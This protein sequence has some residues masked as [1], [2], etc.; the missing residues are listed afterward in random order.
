MEG[1]YTV[2]T[3]CLTFIKSPTWIYLL[4]YAVNQHKL[5]R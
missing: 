1:E 5:I 3:Y 4:N 2:I